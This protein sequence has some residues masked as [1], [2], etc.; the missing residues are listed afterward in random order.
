[1]F[2]QYCKPK[3]QRISQIGE[4]EIIFNSTMKTRYNTGEV[5]PDGNEATDE[6]FINS[7]MIDI[8]V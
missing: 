1:M 8:Y 6:M 7:T 4:L 3:I 2:N 5:L